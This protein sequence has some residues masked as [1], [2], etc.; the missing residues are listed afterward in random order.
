MST[1]CPQR[2]EDRAQPPQDLEQ[3][4]QLLRH[5]FPIGENGSF[6]ILLNAIDKDPAKWRP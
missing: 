3:F 4:A 2:T 1:T 6:A 5:A